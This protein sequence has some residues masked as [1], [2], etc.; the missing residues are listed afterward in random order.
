MGMS[1]WK[2][3][4]CGEPAPNYACE[5]QQEISDMEIRIRSRILSAESKEP[6]INIRAMANLIFIF[7]RE[8]DWTLERTLKEIIAGIKCYFR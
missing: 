6:Y 1:A 4:F 8:N 5:C 7:A 2:C 3:G